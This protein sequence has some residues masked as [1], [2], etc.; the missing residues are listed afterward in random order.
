LTSEIP[1]LR[2]LKYV[3]VEDKVLIVQPAN[4]IIRGV[5]EE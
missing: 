1:L 2:G 3:K 5:I 4:G